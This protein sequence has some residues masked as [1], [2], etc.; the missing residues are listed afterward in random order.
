MVSLFVDT[1][2]VEVIFI[3]GSTVS[4]TI[5]FVVIVSLA[6]WTFFR[7]F[8]FFLKSYDGGGHSGER[9]EFIVFLSSDAD[10]AKSVMM[11]TIPWASSLSSHAGWTSSWRMFIPWSDPKPAYFD[12]VFVKRRS[13][14]VT[15]K[16][17]LN[18]DHILSASAF[19]SQS[20][21]ASGYKLV[22]KTRR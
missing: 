3:P 7:R 11:L 16:Y 13:R 12:A 2:R 22:R 14:C 15:V 17:V 19:L 6:W 18:S 20:R 21:Q 8:I 4:Q 5:T 10:W 1:G 9:T